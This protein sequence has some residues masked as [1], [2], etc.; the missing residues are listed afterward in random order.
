MVN[1]RKYLTVLC[2]EKAIIALIEE[3]GEI[4]FYRQRGIENYSI[5]D[6]RK[7]VRDDLLDEKWSTYKEIPS[8]YSISFED[9]Y[10]M[11]KAY[12][13]FNPNRKTESL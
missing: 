10:I 7:F 1:N 3:D 9:P 13:N 11:G 5:A 12:V 4:N 8:N 2:I 6:R